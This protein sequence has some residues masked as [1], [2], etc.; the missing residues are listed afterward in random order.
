MVLY[1]LEFDAR[2]RFIAG[3]AVVTTVLSMGT[4]TVLLGVLRP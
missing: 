4:L 2:P 3:V 1:S